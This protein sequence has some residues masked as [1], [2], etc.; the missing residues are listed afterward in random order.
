MDGCDRE[1]RSHNSP[2]CE[3]HYQRWWRKGSAYDRVAKPELEHSHGYIVEYHP[4]HP[5]ATA[6]SSKYV[7]QHRRVYHDHHGDGPF[8][9]HHCGITVTWDDMHV[10]HLDD[11][12]ANNDPGNLVASCPTCN[13]ARGV[14]KMRAKMRLR[15]LQVTA[16]GRTRCITEWAADI[17]ISRQSL[18]RRLAE[19]WSPER[20]VSEPRGRFGPASKGK[21]AQA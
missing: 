18:K 14:A 1:R 5:L 13:Q 20:A 8:C 6:G 9:C 11:D 2:Y 17:G 15:G 4:G 12:R 10:D 3:V 19:G 16:F 21:G 7:Y